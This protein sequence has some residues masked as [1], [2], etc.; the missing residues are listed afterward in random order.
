MYTFLA[1][2][3][4]ETL[5]S[6]QN[7]VIEKFAQHSVIYFISDGDSTKIGK[8][9]NVFVRLKELQTGNPR[10][11]IIIA[12]YPCSKRDTTVEENKFH[13]KFENKKIRGE[14]FFLTDSDLYEGCHGVIKF[15]DYFCDKFWHG[16]YKTTP[17]IQ[18]NINDRLTNNYCKKPYYQ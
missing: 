6:K 11:L 16:F 18:R 5:I 1:Q 15:P 7:E 12:I 4:E 3:P 13:K 17:D 8:A 14:W 9:N 2:L 10:R